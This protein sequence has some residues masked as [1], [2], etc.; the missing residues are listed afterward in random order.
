ML[1]QTLNAQVVGAPF[2]QSQLAFEFQR[3][4]DFWQVARIELV[5]KG[6]RA[7]GDNDFFAGAQRGSQIS[8]SFPGTCTGFD[9][10]TLLIFDSRTDG[11]RHQTLRFTGF[12]TFNFLR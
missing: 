3:G 2:E 8:V 9:D 4:G 11:L 6:F 5:L 10:Q 12:K 1:F 7:G